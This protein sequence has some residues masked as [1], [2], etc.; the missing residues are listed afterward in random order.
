MTSSIPERDWKYLRGIMPE[1][2]SELCRKI[3]LGAM[4]ILACESGSE[5]EKYLKL[6]RYLEASDRVV[7]D[8]FNDWRRSTLWFKLPLLSR[9]NVLK[10]EHISNLSDATRE[11]IARF[12]PLDDE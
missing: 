6:Y 1:L 11:L 3:N 4:E 5:H 10:D 12:A 9:H 2:L 8:C 7:A